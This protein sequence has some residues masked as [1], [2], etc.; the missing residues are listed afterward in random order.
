MHFSP[1]FVGLLVCFYSTKPPYLLSPFIF[2]PVSSM[3][4]SYHIFPVSSMSLPYHIIRFDTPMKPSCLLVSWYVF[5]STILPLPYLFAFL[6]CY[7]R[8]S[9]WRTSLLFFLDLRSIVGKASSLVGR[10]IDISGE[11]E[12]NPFP[13]RVTKEKE[14]VL[15]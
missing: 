13:T 12:E 7:M 14:L 8:S 11:I 15:G 5:S 3:F 6:P 2:T 4:P 10:R 1:C 9:V